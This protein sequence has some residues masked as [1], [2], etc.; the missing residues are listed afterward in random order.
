MA[1]ETCF[2]G[3]PSSLG[4][5]VL[6]YAVCRIEGMRQ[7]QKRPVLMA[8]ETSSY[9]MPSSLGYAVLRYASVSK[10]TCFYSKRDLF[11]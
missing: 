10:E 9:G 2:Y 5:A 11:S 1:K 7:C 4:Y 3:M 6:R 8:K